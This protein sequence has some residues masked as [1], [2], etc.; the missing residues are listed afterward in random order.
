MPRETRRSI[1]AGASAI[2]R[3]APKAWLRAVD[4]ARCDL[5]A[6]FDGLTRVPVPLG[7]ID[8][9]ENALP[10]S[11]RLYWVTMRNDAAW[12]VSDLRGQARP[13]LVARGPSRY[14]A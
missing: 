9:I 10:R 1:G 12:L 14:R 6:I 5:N 11:L 8:P 7:A 13:Y 2:A 4:Q 3:M